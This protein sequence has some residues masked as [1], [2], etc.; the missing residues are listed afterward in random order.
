MWEDWKA[1]VLA[2]A[3]I[4]APYVTPN[5][6]NE[7]VPWITVEIK[8]SIHHRDFPR[9]RAVKTKSKYT[10]EA[11]KKARNE[12]NKLIKHTKATYY[13]NAFNHCESNSKELWGEIS[14]LTN[15]KPKPQLFLK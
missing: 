8:R 11:Y 10:H 12:V 5:G 9:K 4:H 1:K 13:M 7:Y 15:K 3:D 6:R 14:D 2:V